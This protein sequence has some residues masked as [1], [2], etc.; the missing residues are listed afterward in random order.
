MNPIWRF[1]VDYFNLTVL[2]LFFIS[3]GFLIFVD[4][5]EYKKEGLKREYIFSKATA[6]VFIFGS[7]A[8]YFVV[9]FLVM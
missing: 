1:L 4:C 9:N 6:Y 3:S 8:V 5:R 2:V 7:L